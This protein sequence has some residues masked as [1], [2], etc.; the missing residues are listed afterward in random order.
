MPIRSFSGGGGGGGG[1]GGAFGTDIENVGG[2]IVF[3]VPIF[4]LDSIDCKNMT[5]TNK[6]LGGSLAKG[7]RVEMLNGNLT[8]PKQISAKNLVLTSDETL[9]CNIKDLPLTHLQ[10]LKDIRPKQFKF[11]GDKSGEIHY[12]F[13]AQDLEKKFPQM[14]STVNN[15]KRV[16]YIEMIPLLLLK[17]QQLEKK[18]DNLQEV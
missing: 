2:E 8:V 15:I 9:K 14:V 3:N 7:E 11:R 4:C 12:G 6:I 17:L 18:I 5:S 13:L 10:I 1:G 16:N